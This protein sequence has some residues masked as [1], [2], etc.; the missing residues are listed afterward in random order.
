MSKVFQA[1]LTGIFFTFI[2]DFFLFLGIQQNYIKLNN[3]DVYYNILFSDNQNIYIYAISSIF[4]GYLIIYLNH[5]IS[6]TIYGVLFLLISLTLF[7][8]IGNFVAKKMFL[9][10]NVIINW[11]KHTY[12][13][14][15]YYNGREFITFYDYE[16]KKIILLDKK[17]IKQFRG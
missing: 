13:G 16:L 6:A 9:K 1:I 4:I 5:K 14:D 2:L 8:E 10:E 17:Y 11:K 15:I 12:N 7:E 3:I